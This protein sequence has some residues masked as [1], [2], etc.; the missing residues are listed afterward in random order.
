MPNRP[1]TKAWR[2]PT[3]FTV[4]AI[5]HGIY[6]FGSHK[7]FF[8]EVTFAMVFIGAIEAWAEYLTKRGLASGRSLPGKL[9][10]DGEDRSE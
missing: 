5:S 1:E 10:P 7:M 4:A 6:I 2:T 9:L 8:A 3:I